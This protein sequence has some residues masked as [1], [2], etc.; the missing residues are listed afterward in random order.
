M[1]PS[2]ETIA[3]G[4]ALYIE[5]KPVVEILATTGMSMGTFYHRC[6]HGVACGDGPSLPALPF[7]RK[8][9]G[10]GMRALDRSRATLVGRLWRAAER[11]VHEIESRLSRTN[12]PADER[13]RDM[14]RLAIVVKTL[15]ELTQLDAAGAKSKPDKAQEDNDDSGPRDMDEFRRELARR[16]EAIIARRRE[17]AAGG[18]ELD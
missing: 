7:R 13:E 2:K 4:R 10:H 6:V 18:P 8:V 9:R 17:R 3:L 12:G 5:N 15:R 11:Q 14:R 16:L 1:P